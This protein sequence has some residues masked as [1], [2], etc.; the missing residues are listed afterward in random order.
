M[1]FRIVASVALM[2]FSSGGA[3]S[4]QLPR[5]STGRPVPPPVSTT[6]LL[7]DLVAVTAKSP[8]GIVEQFT[9]TNPCTTHSH[10]WT[11][12][13][14]IKGRFGST[15]PS[16]TG[17]LYRNGQPIETWSLSVP[18]GNHEVTLGSFTWTKDHP[19]PGGGTSISQ[20]PANN[21]RLVVDPSGKLGEMS[22]GNNVVEFH[23]DPAV[24]FV[25]AP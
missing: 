16:P 17:I 24:P 21:Y 8:T 14:R 22:E 11:V 13:V 7:P 23:I 5:S 1:R 15:V 6:A 10:T 9:Q 3:A 25:R 12:Y 4:A 2:A 20:P 18:A 19:C